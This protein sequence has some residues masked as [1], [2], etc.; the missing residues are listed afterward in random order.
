MGSSLRKESQVEENHEKAAAL[1]VL[2]NA[3]VK[4]EYRGDS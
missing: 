1:G 3:A 4:A 2:L